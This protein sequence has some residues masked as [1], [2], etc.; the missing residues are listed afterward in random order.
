MKTYFGQAVSVAYS[1]VEKSL[2]FRWHNLIPT[3]WHPSC[4]YPC[5]VRSECGGQPYSYTTM[6]SYILK[7]TEHN[8]TLSNFRTLKFIPIRLNIDL[9]NII[10]IDMRKKCGSLLKNIGNSDKII[11]KHDKM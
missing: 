8:R 3:D 2:R 7:T 4:Y 6:V 11:R 1:L 10:P 9:N 5:I